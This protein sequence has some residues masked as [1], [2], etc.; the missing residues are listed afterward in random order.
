MLNRR[1]FLKKSAFVVVAPT[2]DLKP[3]TKKSSWKHFDF[4]RGDGINC[5]FRCKHCRGTFW[6][7]P[8]TEENLK[9]FQFPNEKIKR[10]VP[11]CE[12][13]K[14]HEGYGM[15]L[16]PSQFPVDDGI[17][18]PYILKYFNEDG[19]KLKNVFDW[20]DSTMITGRIF[21]SYICKVFALEKQ[22][23]NNFVWGPVD[24]KLSIYNVESRP[25]NPL[26]FYRSCWQKTSTFRRND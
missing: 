1:D 10:L 9:L 25:N 5:K 20:A 17:R 12:W 24:L 4:L 3:K 11:E 18:L 6:T 7:D 21:S 14:T 16:I 8:C 23:S 19:G 22:F 15:P 13:C 2:L 26:M